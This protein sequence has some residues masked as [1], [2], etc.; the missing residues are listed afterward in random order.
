MNITSKYKPI[1]CETN[2]KKTCNIFHVKVVDSKIVQQIFKSLLK[3]SGSM[4]VPDECADLKVMGAA[5]EA[6]LK[7]QP[8]RAT[9]LKAPKPVVDLEGTID[10]GNGQYL[11]RN[12]LRRMWPTASRG[13]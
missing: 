13:S 11:V 2:L 9:I 4:V 12:R 7:E 3:C 6:R 8:S 1:S 5:C 10:W